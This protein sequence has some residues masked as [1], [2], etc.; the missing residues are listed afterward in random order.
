MKRFVA[1]ALFRLRVELAREAELAP[2]ARRGLDPTSAAR[3][4]LAVVV[5]RPGGSVKEEA[6]LLGNTRLDELSPEAWALGVRPGAT[7]A[8]ARARASELRVRVVHVHAV[9]ARLASIAEAALAFGPTVAYQAHDAERAHPRL[10]DVVWI[11]VT[12]SSHLFGG[13]AALGDAI[14][15]QVRGLGHACRVAIA[16]GPRITAAIARYARD[17]EARP[18][19]PARDDGAPRGARVVPAEET[20]RAV[21]A[22]PVAALPID[23]GTI[24]WLD[25]LG[26]RDVEGVRRLP[27][28]A[29]G[30]RLG[31]AC[32]AFLP[33]LLELVDGVDAT[34]LVPHVPPEIPEERAEIEYG[35]EG[36]E[37]LLFVAKATADRLAARLHARAMA[38]ARLEMILELDRALT[39]T[40]RS[41]LVLALA[42][43]VHAASELFAVLRARV[44]AHEV[45]APIRAVVLRATELVPRRFTPRD[46]FVP[47]A[48]AARALPGLTAELV[49]DLGEDR[50]GVLEIVS[51]WVPE[52]RAKLV[53]YASRARAK[54]RD[55][56][57][58]SSGVEPT[59]LLPAPVSKERMRPSGE[60]RLVARF[61]GI[62]WWRD[63]PAVSDVVVEWRS[64]EGAIAWRRDE[65]VLGWVD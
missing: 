39:D 65:D 31:A 41:V 36:S 10:G 19:K 64:D 50:V 59:R 4:P 55:G 58:V 32:G 5:A 47:E 18:A 7:I 21:G 44:E 1:I 30:T 37:A 57:L 51:T 8:A 46:L 29:L 27:R 11:D 43:P 20:R 2:L 45:D 15:A 14:A 53:P 35:I 62:E 60:R 24:R 16:S 3:A 54:A 33:R 34:P 25:K 52:R 12:G 48:R 28:S 38:T 56:D 9:D 61:E 40:P 26:V 6:S 17:D 23:D 42:S 63:G 13:E 22:L 49:A